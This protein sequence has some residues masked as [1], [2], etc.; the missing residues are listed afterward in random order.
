MARG[1]R[2]LRGLDAAV[3]CGSSLQVLVASPCPPPALC[4]ALCRSRH[5]LPPVCAAFWASSCRAAPARRWPPPAPPQE[6]SDFLSMNCIGGLADTVGVSTVK[7]AGFDIS[8]AG[9][10]GQHAMTACITPGAT[11]RRA[12]ERGPQMAPTCWRSSK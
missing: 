10:R 9:E 6:R 2:R 8:F 4:P 12:C 7:G 5:A 11:V 3:L 1:S